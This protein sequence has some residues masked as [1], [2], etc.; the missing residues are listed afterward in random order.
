M[1]IGSAAIQQHSSERQAL[2][3]R[4]FSSA[5]QRLGPLLTHWVLVAAG[6]EQCLGN[7]AA[8][9]AQLTM[10]PYGMWHGMSMIIR[11]VSNVAYLNQLP[12]DKGI[13]DSWL[14][15]GGRQPTTLKP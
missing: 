15:G 7:N 3:G 9:N 8:D 12:S 2:H 10:Q 1:Q 13:L 5:H 11:L 6:V 14:H 4:L